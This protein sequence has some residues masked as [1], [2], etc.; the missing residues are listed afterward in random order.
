VRRTKVT[1]REFSENGVGGN[2]VTNLPKSGLCGHYR[3]YFRF[4]RHSGVTD[5]FP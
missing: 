1:E 5:H 2:F 4:A 3:G